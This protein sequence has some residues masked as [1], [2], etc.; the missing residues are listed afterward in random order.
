[1]EGNW[2][3]CVVERGI[4][5]ILGFLMLCRENP[6]VWVLGNADGAEIAV[7]KV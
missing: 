6:F 3:M 2:N 5:V 1:M 4:F 7:L